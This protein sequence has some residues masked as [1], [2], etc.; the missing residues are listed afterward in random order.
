LAVYAD[1]G[2][3]SSYGG[4]VERTA[5][6]ATSYGVIAYHNK[7][8]VRSSAIEVTGATAWGLSARVAPGSDTT[9]VADGVNVLR[10]GG[11]SAVGVEA[12]THTMRAPRAL[13]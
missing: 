5:V 3:T 7:T 13:P 10:P 6:A 1:S 11:P 12:T 2:I 8:T 9:V 4:L